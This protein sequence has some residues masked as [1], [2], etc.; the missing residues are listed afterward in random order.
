MP[1]ANKTQVNGENISYIFLLF[2]EFICKIYSFNCILITID[3]RDQL[4]Y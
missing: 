2:L 1:D 4:G 3:P